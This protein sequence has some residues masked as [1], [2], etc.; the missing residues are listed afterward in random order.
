MIIDET[1]MWLYAAYKFGLACVVPTFLS[2][3]AS[4]IGI[5][6]FISS[7]DDQMRIAFRIWK[8]CA[9]VFPISLF[10]AVITPSIY[11]VKTYAKYTIGE[12]VVNS[13]EAKR[14]IEATINKLE[15]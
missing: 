4:L 1:F 8:I 6:F 3:I 15:K 14:I 13:D 5:A 9:V 12:K 11:E 7:N 2:G 10:F